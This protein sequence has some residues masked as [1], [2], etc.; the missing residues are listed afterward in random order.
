M[1]AL[2]RH[3]VATCERRT[4]PRGWDDYRVRAEQSQSGDRPHVPA[5][6]RSIAA[7]QNVK[8]YVVDRDDVGRRGGNQGKRVMQTVQD[9]RAPAT[10]DARQR[11]LLPTGA[12][13]ATDRWHAMEGH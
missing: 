5:P 1:D 13:D 3:A 4:N 9:V 7:W 2:Q 8:C 12:A 11:C 10:D 6:R